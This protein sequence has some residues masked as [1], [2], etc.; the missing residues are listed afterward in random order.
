MPQFI[1]FYFINQVS[2][3]VTSLSLLLFI[4]SIYFFPNFLEVYVSRSYSQRI[5]DTICS[6]KNL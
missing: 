6:A 1:P 4:N 5:L 3:I 2:F